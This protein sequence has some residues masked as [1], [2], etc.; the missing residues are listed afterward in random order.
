MRRN[1]MG[2]RLI[3]AT[4]SSDCVITTTTIQNLAVIEMAAER[5]FIHVYFVCRPRGTVGAKGDSTRPN[6]NKQAYA[7]CQNWKP[8]DQYPRYPT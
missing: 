6:Q 7:D 3:D 4:R 1:H 5:P 8:R 2:T